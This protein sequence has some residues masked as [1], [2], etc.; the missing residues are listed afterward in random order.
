MKRLAVILL[1]L[2]FTVSVS[3][4]TGFSV[5]LNVIGDNEEISKRFYDLMIEKL[6]QSK[7]S[8]SEKSLTVLKIE[9]M[10]SKIE[11][12]KEK[13]KRKMSQIWYPNTRFLYTSNKLD[14]EAFLVYEGNFI[15]LKSVNKFTANSS[16]DFN[17]M[18]GERVSLI[19]NE[20]LPKLVKIKL[21]SI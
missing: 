14:L 6:K 19:V 3:E 5:N 18:I 13:K 17:F 4:A 21:D 7:V 11:T 15:S 10:E 1:F 9:I 12:E 16:K 20:V 2:L 8:V